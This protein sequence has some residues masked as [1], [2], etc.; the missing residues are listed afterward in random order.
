MEDPRL[1]EIPASMGQLE[2]C[3][4]FCRS[5]A[6][7]FDV[8]DW[9]ADF[10]VTTL[11]NRDIW[12]VSALRSN[13][14]KFNEFLDRQWPQDRNHPP[15]FGLLAKLGYLSVGDGGIYLTERALNLL[16]EPIRPPEVFISYKRG[17]GSLF[18]LALE[19]RLIYK[20]IGCFVDKN[21]VGGGEW[22]ADL[23]KQI[24][25]CDRLVALIGPK[26]ASSDF[27]KKEV[28]WALERGK[29]VIPICF[30]GYLME[31]VE[32]DFPG[33]NRQ[34]DWLKV[35]PTTA[36]A[37]DYEVLINFVINALGYSTV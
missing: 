14:E 5:L 31:Q 28:R 6:Y 25:L 24:D 16:K 17:E 8:G 34:G 18:A 10:L 35:D 9:A 4:Y 30:D 20:G 1:I 22:H 19:A 3:E 13:R 11:D 26:A 12:D 37:A 2:K 27:C 32:T 21:L 15:Q 7:G 33:L 23:E 29:T 36:S